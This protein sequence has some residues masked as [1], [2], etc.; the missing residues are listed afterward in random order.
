MRSFVWTLKGRTFAVHVAF[1]SNVTDA[2]IQATNR[3]L[4]SF[5]A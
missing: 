3:A 4:T 2:N 5:A 1:G